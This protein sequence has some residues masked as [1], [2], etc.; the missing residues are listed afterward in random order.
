MFASSCWVL[1]NHSLH[2][3]LIQAQQNFKTLSV[4][5]FSNREANKPPQE[6]KKQKGKVALRRQK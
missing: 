6:S 5:R 3:Q 2:L 4:L 1:I